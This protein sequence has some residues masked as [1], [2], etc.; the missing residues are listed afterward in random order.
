VTAVPL[1]LRFQIPRSEVDRAKAAAADRAP[2]DFDRTHL[3]GRVTFDIGVP[4]DADPVLD[5]L[6]R[7]RG[8]SLGPPVTVALDQPVAYVVGQLAG[9]AVLAL[10]GEGDLS[11]PLAGGRGALSVSADG[12][13][14][15]LGLPLRSYAG[16][17]AVPRV[18]AAHAIAEA[19]AALAE[20]LRPHVAIARLPIAAY[21]EREAKILAAEGGPAPLVEA[22]WSPAAF[23]EGAEEPIE[24]R[25]ARAEAGGAHAVPYWRIERA[26]DPRRVDFAPLRAPGAAAR[27][28]ALALFLSPGES[29]VVRAALPDDEE[30]SRRLALRLRRR[31][32]FSCEF[33]E[34]RLAR[35]AEPAEHL[36]MA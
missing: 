1:R 32:P 26:A 22:T 28:D 18:A 27:A 29:E 11:F 31:S 17:A 35:I 25:S 13:A 34:G 33:A 23:A 30:G 3:R 6:V 20:L 2:A 24:A 12:D 10:R 16:T 5:F 7:E 21:L 15:R 4:L 19:A 36:P 8:L 9:A 14:L